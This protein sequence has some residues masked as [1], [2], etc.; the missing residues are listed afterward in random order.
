[1]PRPVWEKFEFHES[2]YENQPNAECYDVVSGDLEITVSNGFIELD[3]DWAFRSSITGC[4]YI[5]LNA[6]NAEDAISEA[7]CKISEYLESTLKNLTA[8][9]TCDVI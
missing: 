9:P 5:K 4:D 2:V 6:N 3:G 8:I 1:M 7:W